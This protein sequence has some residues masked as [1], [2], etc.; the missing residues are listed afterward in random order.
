MRELLR[1]TT[2]QPQ[3]LTLAAKPKEGLFERRKTGE[4]G[5]GLLASP[6]ELRPPSIFVSL[7]VLLGR[8]KKRRLGGGEFSPQD[9]LRWKPEPTREGRLSAVVVASCGRR[10][11]LR[12]PVPL[13]GRA[14]PFQSTG[15]AT[16]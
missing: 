8:S 2:P 6:H 4:G 14:K 1:D 16:T 13:N 5:S 3:R 7:L 10:H 15:V 9:G 12:T 11:Q